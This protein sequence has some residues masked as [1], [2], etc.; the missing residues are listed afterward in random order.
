MDAVIIAGGEGKRM[1]SELPKALV[2]VKGKPIL[3]WQI[4]YLINSGIEKI[5][6][7]IG[8]KAE[9]IVD[10]VE[11]NYNGNQIDFTIEKKLLGTAGA[12][13]MA[14]QKCGSEFV[15]VLNCD[16][17]TDIDIKKL[18]EK[19]EDTICVAH[20][21]LHFGRVAEKNGYAV[22]EE[23][24]MLND[25]VSCGWYLL[26]REGML[27]ILP[28]KGMLEYDVFPKIKLRV[29]KHEGFWKTFNTKKDVDEFEGAELP[30]ALK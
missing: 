27:E 4:D 2:E 23:K 9:A 30:V 15:V 26:N 6:L 16:D 3:A 19:R 28:D 11:N 13:K 10:Y 5:V 29:Y 12:V 24:P 7:A 25:W 8:H 21:S 20:P 18:K 1:G 17:L 14:L 22:F